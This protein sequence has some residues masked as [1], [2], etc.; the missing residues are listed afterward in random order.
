MQLESNICIN[1][2]GIQSYST[3]TNGLLKDCMLNE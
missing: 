3:Y 2:K 1:L